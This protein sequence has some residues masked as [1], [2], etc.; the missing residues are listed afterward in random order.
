[1][2]GASNQVSVTPA[3]APQTPNTPATPNEPDPIGTG[4]G[5]LVNGKVERAGTATTVVVNGQKVTTVVLDEG[6]LNQRLEEEGEGAM[7]TIPVNTGSDVVTVEL[8]GQTVKNMESLGAVVEVRT[9]QGVYTLPAQQIDIDAV[10]G[11]FGAG[12]EDI[13]IQIEIATPV[14]ETVQFVKNTFSKKG[15]AIVVPPVSF[16]VKAVYGDQTEEITVFNAYVE[17]LI[18][19]PDGV[20]PGQ[21]TTCVVMDPDGT[22]RHV[23]TKIVVIDGKYYAQ[24]NSLTNSIYSAVNHTVEFEDMASH[25]AKNAVNNMGSRMIVSGT[26]DGLFNP[27][28]DITRAEFAAIMV[29]GLGLRPEGGESLFADVKD[30][31]WYNDV[32]RTAHAFGLINGFADGTFRPNEKITREQ[33]MLI[34]S[35]A[36]AIT[37]LQGV[38]SERRAAE[39]L[40]AFADAGS[41]SSW[42]SLGIADSVRAGVVM[43]R[44][45]NV[46]APKAYI[47]RAEVAMMMQRLLQK[48]DLI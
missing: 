21:I 30:S 36:M 23:P 27:D 11:R 15:I 6:R 20:D 40:Q 32:I 45:S 18:A 12:T 46:L 41:V 35:R 48:S 13:K 31:D 44:S 34:I 4:E 43:G 10:A 1:M 2:S 28:Q 16:S 5:I 47:T 25:W 37:K 38:D 3:T 29:R 17:R 14:D 33:A 42:A 9:E 19:I 8:G 7:I 22:I 24:V 26:G 39:V